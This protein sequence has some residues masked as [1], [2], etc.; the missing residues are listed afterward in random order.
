MTCWNL[1]RYAL[2]SC[3]AGAL[4]AGC[5]GTQSVNPMLHA[6]VV[7]P[8]TQHK[9][10]NYTGKEQH[11]TVPPN[12]TKV[13]IVAIGAHGGGFHGSVRALPG[14]TRAIVPV[15]PG[16]QLAVFVGG[17]GTNRSSHTKPDDGGF[18]GGGG[19]GDGGGTGEGWGG[20]GASDVRQGGDSPQDRIVIAGGGGG[21]ASTG[22]SGYGGFAGKG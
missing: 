13:T 7:E 6:S 22:G 20:G 10:F 9:T 3:M 19:G 18:N 1:S 14:R 8:G 4:L 11:F 15:T 2:T 21:L 16:E 17:H 5:G 12:V